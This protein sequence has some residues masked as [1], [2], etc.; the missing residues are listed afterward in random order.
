MKVCHIIESGATG[1]L[2]MVLLAAETQRDL[3][4]Q[5]CIVYCER[6][7]APAHLRD[8][9]HPDIR[10]IRLRMRPLMPFLPLWCV[11]CARILRRWRPDVLLL[12]S[13][14]AGFFG[15]LV[16][17][18][19]FAARTLHFTHCISFMHIQYSSFQRGCFR[20]LERFAHAFCPAAYV[21]Q[22]EPERALIAREL[23]G[24]S[25]H[26]LE[27]AVDDLAERT[28]RPSAPESPPRV[29][30]CARIAP[31]KD[32]QLFA[33]VC[34]AARAIRPDIEFEWIGDGDPAARLALRRAGV[35]V[36]GWLERDA[37]LRRI[38]GAS[39]FLLTSLHETTP[40]CVLEAM[41]LEVPVVCRNAEWS[42]DVVRDGVNG[43]LFDDVGAAA[44]ILTAADSDRFAGVA[45][46]A[47]SSARKRYSQGRYAA[48]LERICRDLL[49]DAG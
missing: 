17:G 32:P 36:T 33:E 3:G 12:H 21:A 10:L 30:T 43:F 38:A 5:V 13:S 48:E 11:R 6:P 37:A 24:A 1:A 20:I 44:A 26:L 7:G 25:V 19:R 23:V 18:P 15:R 9:V 35:R 40:V 42:A 45:E 27:N 8:R 2:A 46:T 47:L 4:H 16:A 41:F 22:S 29:V 28:F 49:A 31:Q 34:R 14:F 39:A